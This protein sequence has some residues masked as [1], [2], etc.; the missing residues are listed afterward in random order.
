MGWSIE[1]LTTAFEAWFCKPKTSTLFVGAPHE[2]PDLP[3]T[4]HVSPDD[5]LSRLASTEASQIVDD[6]PGSNAGATLHRFVVKTSQTLHLN[7]RF[8]VHVWSQKNPQLISA[9]ES[10][11]LSHAAF[12]NC[13]YWLPPVKAGNTCAT[14]IVQPVMTPQAAIAALPDT[15]YVFSAI[16]LPEAIRITITTAMDAIVCAGYR[17]IKIDF[18]LYDIPA[19]MDDNQLALIS[20]IITK[21]YSVLQITVPDPI[22]VSQAEEID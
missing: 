10:T 7:K 18:S 9:W 21:Q 12:V 11:G 19:C 4:Y 22:S 16:Y 15:Y 2:L 1:K 13:G 17:S 6:I 8:L 5:A 14:L 3:N 20:E